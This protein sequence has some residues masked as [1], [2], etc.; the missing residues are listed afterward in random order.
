MT[1]IHYD[2]DPLYNS[3]INI[4]S[5][6]Y[7]SMSTNSNITYYDILSKSGTMSLVEKYENEANLIVPDTIYY[8]Q[9]TYH[10]V[11]NTI[12]ILVHSP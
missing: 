8:L 4:Y 11:F 12:M 1:E 9:C 6:Y 7:R 2:S 10:I 3:M 5:K